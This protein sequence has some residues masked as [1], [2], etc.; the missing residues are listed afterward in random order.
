MSPGPCT[1]WRPDCTERMFLNNTMK[2]ITPEQYLATDCC[3]M[4]FHGPVQ[5]KSKRQWGRGFKFVVTGRLS[6]STGPCCVRLC[7]GWEEQ[8]RGIDITVHSGVGGAERH[9]GLRPPYEGFAIFSNF[10]HGTR[11]LGSELP[12][13]ESICLPACCLLPAACCLPVCQSASLSY[14]P[15]PQLPPLLACSITSMPTPRN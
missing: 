4:Y 2:C 15:L 7:L 8:G 11:N 6:S 3:M 5:Y 1:A 13:M 14:N 9:S 10:Q 12:S